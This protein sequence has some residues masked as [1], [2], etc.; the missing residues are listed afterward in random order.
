MAETI[1]FAPAFVKE[2][3]AAGWNART[4]AI[5]GKNPC[6]VSATKDIES[7]ISVRIQAQVWDGAGPLGMYNGHLSR[8]Y[9]KSYSK[10]GSEDMA[11]YER[12]WDL[13]ADGE[14]EIGG[15][16]TAQDLMDEVLVAEY[17]ADEAIE[18]PGDRQVDVSWQPREARMRAAVERGRRKVMATGIT[19]CPD[20][21]HPLNDEEEYGVDVGVNE[22]HTYSGSIGADG[23]LVLSP[24]SEEVTTSDLSRVECHECGADLAASGIG[25][26]G[27]EFEG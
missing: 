6:W 16:L 22:T 15:G 25:D 26:E 17:K 8:F 4:Q 23:V 11:S 24:D 3:R 12:G 20:C 14:N 7:G 27:Y 5:E 10:E 2:L 18:G 1:E 13:L 19:E 21:G 9:M